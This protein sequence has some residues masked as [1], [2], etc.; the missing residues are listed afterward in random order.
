M[1]KIT[2][3]LRAIGVINTHDLL[4]QF[5]T[6]KDGYAIDYHRHD[7]HGPGCNKTAVW[8]PFE[9]TD[10]EGH[11]M[12]RGNKAFTGNRVEGRAEALAWICAR[13]KTKPGDW[14]PSPIDPQNVR[15]HK[16]VRARA[17][18]ALKARG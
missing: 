2:D 9:K 7:G 6:K 13:T 11:W 15:V 1:S 18:A 12:N 17:M 16:D 8:S 4:T 14:V 3:A 5:A 10:P